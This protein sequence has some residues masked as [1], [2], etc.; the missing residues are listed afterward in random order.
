MQNLIELLTKLKDEIKGSSSILIR[1]TH[2]IN[3]FEIIVNWKDDFHFSGGI[4]FS[5]KE[6]YSDEESSDTLDKFIHVANFERNSYKAINH[7]IRD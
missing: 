4:T 2:S 5:L 6:T 3:T 1:S 7:K